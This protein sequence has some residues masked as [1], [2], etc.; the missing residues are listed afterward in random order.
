MQSELQMIHLDWAWHKRTLTPSSASTSTSDVCWIDVPK[1]DTYDGARNAIV[2]D[3]FLF[4]LKQY[5]NTMG[6]RDDT[7]KVGTAPTFIGSATQLWWRWKYGEMGKGI[8]AINTWTEFRREFRKHFA[9]SNVEK[10]AQ[11][12]LRRLKKMGSVHDYIYDYITLM[13]EISD[14]SNKDSFFYFQDGL[15][16]WAKAELDGHGVQTLDDAIAVVE[17][18]ANYSAQ[19]KDKRPIYDKGGGEGHEDNGHNRKDWG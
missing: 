11:A 8:C 7:L 4:G 2:V 14:M 5:F 16:D 3:N 6:V 12:R 18:L 1:P 19:P 17:S 9:P 10:E 15:K 13:L